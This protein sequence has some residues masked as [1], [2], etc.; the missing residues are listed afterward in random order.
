MVSLGQTDLT[1]CLAREGKYVSGTVARN[2]PLLLVLSIPCI[3]FTETHV[4]L[5][6]L[7]CPCSAKIIIRAANILITS[8]QA[9][10]NII[11]VAVLLKLF[12]IDSRFLLHLPCHRLGINQNSP[13]DEVNVFLSTSIDARSVER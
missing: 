12:Y 10:A 9:L 1:I 8:S 3:S 4:R 6:S 2:K 13:E 7:E 11:F 5:F